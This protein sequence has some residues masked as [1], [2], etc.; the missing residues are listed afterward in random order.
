ML[1]VYGDVFE[2]SL[3]ACFAAK[4][5]VERILSNLDSL[6]HSD[7]VDTSAVSPPLLV[8]AQIRDGNALLLKFCYAVLDCISCKRHVLKSVRFWPSCTV[9]KSYVINS[10]MQDS[11]D[12][13]QCFNPKDSHS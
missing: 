8:A 6:C 5:F 13:W 4:S 9:S 7:C 3:I 10:D 1:N 12:G 11:S 2:K